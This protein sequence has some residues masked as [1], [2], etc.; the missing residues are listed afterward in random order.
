MFQ[1]ETRSVLEK[2]S[3]ACNAEDVAPIL[4]NF[5]AEMG[6][7][8][9]S[10]GVRWPIPITR[11]PV[12]ILHNYPTGWMEHYKERNFLISDPT[13]VH[14]TRSSD[15]I[16]WDSSLFC[17]ATTLWNDAQDRGL[18][19]GVA[20]SS[21][22]NGGTFGLL[23]AARTHQPIGRDEYERL[24][25]PFSWAANTFHAKLACILK[26]SSANISSV[27]LTP[28]ERDVVLWTAEGKTAIE[29]AAIL[30]CTKRTVEF[31]LDNSTR[32]LGASNKTHAVVYALGMGLLTLQ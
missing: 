1:I 16:Y 20:Q 26:K 8:Y 25:L 24:R 10:Y 12:D 21:W 30:G 18:R 14:G 13:I 17:T 31:H 11:Q 6:F 5:I 9:F 7:D 32:K 28:R 4:R 29:I 2:I 3:L 15:L 23:S 27:T 22:A 19:H